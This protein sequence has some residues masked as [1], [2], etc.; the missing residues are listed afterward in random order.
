HSIRKAIQ[1][2]ER[3]VVSDFFSAWRAAP[4]GFQDIDHDLAASSLDGQC[5]RDTQCIA[6]SSSLHSRASK[7]NLR[8][9]LRVKKIC[10]TETRVASFVA[11]SDAGGLDCHLDY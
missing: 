7:V 8:V 9:F 6:I 2:G 1:S 11:G 10:R 4:I 3:R 5:S